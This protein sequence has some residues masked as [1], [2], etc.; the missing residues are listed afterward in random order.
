MTATEFERLLRKPALRDGMTFAIFAALDGAG[1]AV[2]H[3]GIRSRF[4]P[5]AA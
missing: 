4:D 5:A 2:L 3:A 1:R